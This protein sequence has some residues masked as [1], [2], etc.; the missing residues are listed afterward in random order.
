LYIYDN[1]KRLPYV[2]KMS[3]KL[4]Q[5]VERKMLSILK[6]LSS[7]QKPAGSVVIAKNLKDLGVDLSERAVRYHLRLTDERG[8]TELVTGRDGRVITI[9][10]RR[11]IER[12][13]V[14]DKVGFAISRIE[15]L[16][17]RTDF[18]LETL[19][20]VIPAN[21]SFFHSDKF[22][23]AWEIMAPVYEKGYCVS[24][25]V[26]VA[27]E[28]Q[29]LGDI[30]VP[31]GYTGL[32]SACS[33]VINGVL[34]K[35]GIPMDSRFGGILQM[36]DHVPVRFTEIIHY[37][38]SS[39]DPSEMFIKAKMTSVRE[40]TASGNGEILANFRETPAI[41]EPIVRNVVG[42]L[43][44]AGLNGVLIIGD[45]SASVCEVNVDMNKIGI[46]LV[47]GL[48][49]VAAAVEAGFVVENHSM[50]TVMDYKTLADYKEV[51]KW[52]QL[53]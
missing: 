53:K 35:A 24:N 9:K 44:Q 23:E 18:N 45:T 48:N 49:P 10:G 29:T 50:C 14:N 4:E 17:F 20:G 28:G 1:G 46:V 7:L 32:A 51:M 30:V 22:K 26:A 2:G 47:G 16:A 52:V 21:I 19:S 3:F 39:L 6:V 31:K 12:A 5:K 25:L 37:N 38:G 41:C 33:I 8:L 36:Q 15:S 27:S 34:L 43:K 11:E 40:T 42:R 13:L